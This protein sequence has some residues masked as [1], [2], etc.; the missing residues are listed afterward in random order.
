MPA[1]WVIHVVGPVR[2]RAARTAPHLLGVVL[3]QRAARRR[4]ARRDERRLPGGVGRHL[5]LADRRRRRRRRADRCI[6]IDRRRPTCGSC[7]STTRRWPSSGG[8]T[9]SSAD[10]A[11]RRSA[12][13]CPTSASCCA[14]TSRPTSTACTRPS[15]RTAT[16][17]ARTCRG[18]TRVATSSSAFLTD[19]IAQWDR[20]ADRNY[21]IVDAADGASSAGAA[22]TTG[23]APDGP[24]D[25]LLAAS[26]TR[27][28]AA[29][30]RPRR[31]RSPTPALAIDGVTRVEIHC[32]EA[33]V[34]S[35][36]VARRLGY[37]LDRIEADHVSAPGD[38]GRSMIWVWPADR[39][40]RRRATLTAR[41]RRGDGD[42]AL[43]E[44]R[45]IC[46]DLPGGHRTPQPR[47]ADVVR[48]RQEDVRDVPR[49]PPRRRAPGHL[50][51]GAARRRRSSSS[52]RSRAAS[53]GRRTSATAAGSACE[54]D[55]DPDWDEMAEICADA[56]RQVAPKTLVAALDA[57]PEEDRPMIRHTVMFRFK[58]GTTPADD[59]RH[60]RGPRRPAPRH[61]GDRRLPLRPRHRRQRRQLRLRRRGRLRRHRRLP[62]LPRP[63]AAPGADRR[64]H[65][66]AR[67]GAGRGAV[68]DLTALAVRSGV[69]AGVVRRGS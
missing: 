13:S 51:R 53:S 37:R 52:S 59:R 56:Y 55:V 61:P 5:R 31:A 46:L 14:A 22:C 7:C 9:T 64:A 19:A 57:R 8:P 4:R 32:D 24:R 68:R 16:T 11:R 20:G 36:A 34:R 48:A 27:R 10:D 3:P 25:R 47:L 35:A 62:R 45:R 49:R 39:P 1:R 23:S 60:R 66:P 18:P 12:S 2:T 26:P 41:V 38:L 67:R 43:D 42:G 21:A 65:R 29:S 30:S 69:A 54:L 50:V 40:G 58:P 33:N 17:S 44:V 28:G 63:P 15:R 6:H